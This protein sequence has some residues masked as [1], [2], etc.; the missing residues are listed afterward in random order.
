MLN[1]HVKVRKSA[2][3]ENPHAP[4]HTRTEDHLPGHVQTNHTPVTTSELLRNVSPH[5][6]TK[7][8]LLLEKSEPTPRIKTQSKFEELRQHFSITV[9]N[10]ESTVFLQAKSNI[11]GDK[12]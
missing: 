3:P 4:P 9:S 2:P 11:Q 7:P 5:T 8:D 6:T 10:E 12:P 1:K